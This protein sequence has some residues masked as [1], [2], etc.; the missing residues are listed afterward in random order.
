MQAKLTRL[1]GIPGGILGKL[2]ICDQTFMTLERLFDGNLKIASGKIYTCK[3]GIHKLEHMIEPFV[4]FCIDVPGH[5]NI[6]FHVGNYV[7]DTDGCVLLGLCFN[8]EG[9]KQSERAFT[10]FMQITAPYEE[11][12]LAVYDS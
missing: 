11:F 7:N 10:Q 5:T 9:L 4:T 2:D 1:Y 3:R 6:L 8:A 12:D